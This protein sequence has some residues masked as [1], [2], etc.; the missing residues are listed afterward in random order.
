MVLTVRAGMGTIKAKKTQ[1]RRK[2]KAVKSGSGK[3]ASSS[4]AGG[5]PGSG[6][7]LEQ[8]NIEINDKAEVDIV[9]HLAVC[10]SQDWSKVNH[11]VVSSF[12]TAS[13]VQ[14]KWYTKIITKRTD[15]VILAELG[16]HYRAEPH[17]RPAGRGEDAGPVVVLMLV[18]NSEAWH[19]VL[20]AIW[21]VVAN[22]V[23]CLL[24][25][26]SIKQGTKYDSPMSA[27]DIPGFIE[28]HGLNMDEVL[29]PL[30]LFSMSS[31]IAFSAIAFLTCVE[32]F[33][34]FFYRYVHSHSLHL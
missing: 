15:I 17:D 27:N 21:K 3:K 30:K 32:T 2:P 24:K 7:G 12:I 31:L 1:F 26:L 20:P 34:Q 14:R 5:G 28:S 8:D 16:K 29:N 25:S 23:C 11:I 18:A 13:Q 19:R 33:K 22:I 10:A 6:S 4:S 9:T